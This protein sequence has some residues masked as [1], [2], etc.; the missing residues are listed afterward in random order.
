MALA[1]HRKS[2]R[3]EIAAYAECFR[4]IELEAL[5][6]AVADGRVDLG[7]LPPAAVLVLLSTSSHG[8]VNEK[9]IG[10]RTGHDEVDALV[11]ELLVRAARPRSE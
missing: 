3:G 2:I 4:A 8:L 11:E 5:E 6:R 10:M 9:V 1:N 7:G